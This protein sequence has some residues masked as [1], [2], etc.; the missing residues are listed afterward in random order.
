MATRTRRNLSGGTFLR[1]SVHSVFSHGLRFSDLIQTIVNGKFCLLD[2][3]ET[4]AKLQENT[5]VYGFPVEMQSY[6]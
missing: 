2:N 1:R 3:F 4:E 6:Q 5:F